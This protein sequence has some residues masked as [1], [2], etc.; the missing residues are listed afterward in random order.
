MKLF[1]LFATV[2][3]AENENLIDAV[4]RVTKLKEIAFKCMEDSFFDTP[5]GKGRILYKLHF[6]NRVANNYCHL[7][8][9]AA[10]TMIAEAE[11]EETNGQ[12]INRNDPCLCIGEVLDGYK[13]FFNRVIAD[14]PD[15]K[16]YKQD[17]VMKSAK[18]IVNNVLN[19]KFGCTL[20]NE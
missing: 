11:D 18:K 9:E 13:S 20:P 16:Y 15:S 6:F 19:K 17:R 7:S 5:R 2:A 12:Q 3:L 10:I 4:K 14:Y 8:E 1:A